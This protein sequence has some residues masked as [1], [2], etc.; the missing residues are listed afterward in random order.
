MKELNTYELELV[1]GCDFD[2]TAHANIGSIMIAN[3]LIAVAR[4]PVFQFVALNGGSGLAAYYGGHAAAHEPTSAAGAAG[5][6]VGGLVSGPIKSPQLSAVV[7]A[8]SGGYAG[9]KIEE[10]MKDSEGW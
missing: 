4:S 5:A 2:Q 1:S 10:A 8:V 6:F 3:G 9:Y 7:S